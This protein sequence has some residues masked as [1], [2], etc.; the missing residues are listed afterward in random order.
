MSSSAGVFPRRCSTPTWVLGIGSPVKQAWLDSG[1]FCTGVHPGVDKSEGG[2]DG[3]QLSRDS[4]RV[5]PNLGNDT[6]RGSPGPGFVPAILS[7]P[8]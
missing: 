3:T 7:F 5:A 6:L 4:H 8:D 2:L 1:R